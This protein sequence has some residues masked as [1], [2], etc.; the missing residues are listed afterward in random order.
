MTM[1]PPSQP[2]LWPETELKSTPSVE[3]SPV[4]TYHSLASALAL[5]VR[6]LV[7]G[8][9]TGVSLARY[10]HALS[11][12]K[13]CQD[14]LVSGSEP[15]SGTW[16]RSGMMLSG[17]VYRLLP[18][19]P[20]TGGTGSGLLP[21]PE[22]SN[23]KAVAMRSGGRPQRDFTGRWPTPRANDAEKRG[24]I[25]PTNPRNGLPGAVKM[26][27]TPTTRDWKDGSAQAC[28]NVPANGLLGRVVHQ[29]P[30]PR[31]QSAKGSGPSRVGNK[32]DL[33]TKVK[34]L[35]LQE[36]QKILDQVMGSLNA[37]WVEWLMGFPTGWTN[38]PGYKNPKK[39][40]ASS[41]DKKTAPTG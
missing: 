8:E 19:A 35:S 32:T 26:W 3:A 37:D 41:K 27:P 31:A 28:Q 24:E 22:A 12:W 39:P 20:L 21:T 16:P 10:D 15:F 6:D 40:R 25:D 23:T 5:K 38:T 17:T 29:F 30:T 1:S 4:R 9:S 14:C 34:H 2:T 18:S 7:C 11:S 13:T 33:Q 36:D